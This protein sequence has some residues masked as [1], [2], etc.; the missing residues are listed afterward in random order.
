MNYDF[1][2]G[3]PVVSIVLI[4]FET[5]SILLR[6]ESE[7]VN[8]KGTVTKLFEMV[9]KS[10]ARIIDCSSNPMLIENTNT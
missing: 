1:K 2:W 4:N 7:G 6:E 9:N 8:T 5:I 3:N 10:C